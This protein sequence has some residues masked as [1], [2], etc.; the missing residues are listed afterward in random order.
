MRKL[1]ASSLGALTLAS[2]LAFATA[3]PAGAVAV[4]PT[5]CGTLPAQA[6]TANAALNVANIA[7]TTAT[8][9]FN[10]ARDA[11]NSAFGAYATAVANWL[12]AV[13][14]GTGVAD[15]KLTM[16]NSLS[17]LASKISAWS[18]AKA[19]VFNAQNAVDGALAALNLLES[20]GSAL[21]CPL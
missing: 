3:A 18:A 6:T 14:A 12:I 2:G 11:M 17:Q 1:I 21:G 4:V 10:S 5:V 16:D 15:A 19:G 20:F 13:D 7:L 9:T 8:N